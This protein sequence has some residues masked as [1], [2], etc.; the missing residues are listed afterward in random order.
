MKLLKSLVVLLVI[1]SIFFGGLYFWGFHTPESKLGENVEFRVERGSSLMKI[2]E[3]L[4]QAELIPNAKLFYYYMRLKKI[5]GSVKAGLFEIPQ[6]AGVVRVSQLLQNPIPEGVI[7]KVTEGMNVWQT[8]GALAEQFPADSATIVNL[9][10]DTAFIASLGLENDTSLE[11]YL[12]PETYNF[13]KDA[14]EKGIISIMV[15]QFSRIY[16]SLP[17]EGHGA[18]MSRHE[19]VTLASIVEKEAQ[20]AHERARISAVFHNRLDQG[21]PLGADPTVR[22]AIK[23]FSGPLRVS[24][25]RNPSPYNT[26]I[27]KGLIP[28]P[29]CSPGKAAL[30]ATVQPIKSNELFFVAKWDGSGEHY[31][32]KTNAEHNRKKI[33]VRKENKELSNW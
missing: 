33:Q 8:A 27:H 9:C 6:N 20:V 21:I 19:L 26:R 16:D 28:G 2:A 30:V 14:D 7:V 12:F 3:N 13:P 23:K 4:E 29:I 17:T 5:S 32:S 31:F 24:E 18:S 11:G 25:L 10:Y 15:K 1:A 22:Y